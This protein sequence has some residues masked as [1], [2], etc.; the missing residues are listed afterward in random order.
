M[1]ETSS[2]EETSNLCDYENRKIAN[3]DM[4][5]MKDFIKKYFQGRIYRNPRDID[6]FIEDIS[7]YFSWSTEEVYTSM[8]KEII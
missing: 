3:E 5:I 8:G 7:Y 6:E 4:E 2:D 1:E